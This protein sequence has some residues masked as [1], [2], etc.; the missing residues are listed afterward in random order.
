M[1]RTVIHQPEY[2]PWINLFTKMSMCETFIF[3]DN[4]QYQRRSYQNRNLILLNDN[5]KLLT[6]PLEYATQQTLISDIKIDNS[7]QWINSHINLIKN[8]YQKTQ[9]FEEVFDLIE[10]EYKKKFIF[11]NDL[12]KNLTEAIAK[13]LK[14]KCKFLSAADMNVLGKKSDLI[15]DIC[16][17]SKTKKYITGTGSKS[18]L[19]VKEFALNEIEIINLKP[20]NFKYEQINNKS[21]FVP[22]LSI[23]DFLFNHGFEKFQDISH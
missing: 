2:L 20:I 21:S 5:S 19:D 22:N 15:L 1:Y 23:V 3:L 12:N 14:M 8:C 7:Q 16:K 4:V 18:Y 17:K 9:Y 6:V 13:K 10:N 11:L